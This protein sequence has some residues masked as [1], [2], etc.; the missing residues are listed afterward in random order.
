MTI[1]QTVFLKLWNDGLTY[2]R[3]AKAMRVG[4]RQTFKWRKALNLRGRP[5][6]GKR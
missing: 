1:R 6:G 5:R 3:I 2:I 4:I